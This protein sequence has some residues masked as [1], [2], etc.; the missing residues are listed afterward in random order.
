MGGVAGTQGS[1]SALARRLAQR[2][3]A[4]GPISVADYMDEVSACYYAA[5]DPLGVAGDFITAP[6][7]SQIFGELIGAWCV[8]LWQRLGAPDPVLLVELGPGRGTLL[9]DA[10]R[11]TRAVPSFARALRLHLVERS[12][13]LRR[14]QAEKLG[15]STPQWHEGLAT[16]PHGPMLLI[17]N[18]FLDA[19][20]IRQFERRGATWHE[21]RIAL[22]A[23]GESLNWALEPQPS[24]LASHLP[25]AEHGM[26]AE[27]AP[28]AAAL[29]QALG[30]RLSQE[31]GAALFIDYGSVAS[32]GGDTLQAVRHHRR[33]GVL[34]EPGSA[35]LTAHVDFAAFAVAAR[36]SGAESFG[37][38]TQGAFLESLGIAAR[39]ARLIEHAT[40]PQ[41]QAIETG[42]RR[43]IDPDAMG[44][45]FKV[46]ALGKKG[47]ATPSGFK[48]E[49]P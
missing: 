41:A 4:T 16:L 27:L 36:A 49:T 32:T 22:G 2:I 44:S 9:A 5:R 39:A 1:V 48:R 12:P 29:G 33:H 19:L 14:M 35:D 31:G 21:R 26:V 17:A 20:P 37:P 47:A 15:A 45:L 10:L 43:L 25:E 28:A 11:A 38:V 40:P 6:E 13:V 23:D 30:A 18:E 46:L 34:E 3:R 24:L 7:I 8:D 42:C